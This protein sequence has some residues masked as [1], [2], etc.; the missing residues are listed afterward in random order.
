MPLSALREQALTLSKPYHNFNLSYQRRK[1]RAAS[2]NIRHVGTNMQYGATPVVAK[3]TTKPTG[4]AK[5]ISVA[6]WPTHSLIVA[7]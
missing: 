3:K 5:L 6:R 1:L 7:L 2:S 4:P